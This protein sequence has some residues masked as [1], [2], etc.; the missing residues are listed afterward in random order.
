MTTNFDYFRDNL[1]SLISAH[2]FN[3]V[4][5]VEDDDGRTQEIHT[6][7]DEDRIAMIVKDMIEVLT[8]Y[9]VIEEKAIGIDERIFISLRDKKPL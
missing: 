3:R 9:G 7:I 5:E 1:T 8:D 4:V 6:T 2:L